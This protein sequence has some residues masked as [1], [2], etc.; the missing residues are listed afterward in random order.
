M[1]LSVHYRDVIWVSWYI[2]SC[3]CGHSPKSIK[4]QHSWPIMRGI[5]HSGFSSQMAS[6]MENIPMLCVIM[7]T[8]K[9]NKL[10]SNFPCP[11]M[12]IRMFHRTNRTLF[13]SLR[14]SDTYMHQWTDHHWFRYWL[15]DWS[16]PSHYQNR[17]WN[18]VNSNLRN[19]IQWKLEGNPYIF[20]Q[21]NVVENVI[22]EMT[23]NLSRPQCVKIPWPL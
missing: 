18:I 21:E 13:N 4:T 10:T 12:I 1:M 23:T 3:L 22:C 9:L 8:P 16:A 5:H 17:C 15:V 20:I 14:P 2:K 6:N 11:L 7:L 19:K